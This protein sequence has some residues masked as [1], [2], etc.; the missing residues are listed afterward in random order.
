MFEKHMPQSYRPRKHWTSTLRSRAGLE[1]YEHLT[2]GTST[3]TI[4]DSLGELYQLIEPSESHGTVKKLLDCNA[5]TT[6]HV[7]VVTT[8]SELLGADFLLGSSPMRKVS[9][10]SITKQ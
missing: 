8:A 1:P 9:R 5:A 4:S 10:T 3:F 2:P 7:H 6:F